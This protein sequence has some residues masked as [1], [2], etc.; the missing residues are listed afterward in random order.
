MRLPEK[1][2][3][4][5]DM[6]KLQLN[7]IDKY[8][9]KSNVI[10]VISGLLLS[11][12]LS[13]LLKNFPQTPLL[14]GMTILMILFSLATVALILIFIRPQMLEGRAKGLFY[15][16]LQ[17]PPS[18][19]KYLKGLEETFKNESKVISMYASEIQNLGEILKPLVKIVRISIVFLL[20]SL[21]I[22]LIATILSL[23]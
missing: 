5:R 11:F 20:L 10:L 3:I 7:A 8:Y 23:F 2:A 16:D 17:N 13:G 18:F 14:K 6:I 22:G 21:V 19:Q 12:T 9:Q 4:L 15:K 1:T